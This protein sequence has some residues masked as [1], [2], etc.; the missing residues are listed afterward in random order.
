[1]RPAILFTTVLLMLMSQAVVINT[2]NNDEEVWWGGVISWYQYPNVDMIVGAKPLY[3]IV[4]PDYGP[5][6]EPWDPV[7]LER[8]HDAGIKVIAYLNIGFAEEW[9]DYWNTTWN[10]NNHPRWLYWV[11]YPDWPGEYFV[12]YWDPSAWGENGWV[13]ILK[14]ELK[15]IISMGFDGVRLD[16]IDSC[17][18]WE[19]PASY[20]L[21]D[22]LPQ[23]DNATQWMIY[24]VGNLSTY[25]KTLKEDF[26]I[27]ANMGGRLDLL[28]NTSFLEAIDIV[29]REDVWY[30]DN[31]PVDPDETSEALYWLRYARDH[32]KRVI[33]TDYAWK[34][35]YVWDALTKA[36]SEG[37]Y[38]Y[39]APSIDLD[40]LALYI[41]VYGWI[42]SVKTVNDEILVVWSYRGTYNN[43]W[44]ENSIYLGRITQNNTVEILKVLTGNDTVDFNPS[45][46]YDPDN[47]YVLCVWETYTDNGKVI[48]GVLID[49]NDMNIV[50]DIIIASGNN[51]GLPETIYYNGLFYIFYINNS[52][53]Y[54][55]VV[56]NSGEILYRKYIGE[57]DRKPWI[58][59]ARGEG[60]AVTWLCSNQSLITTK[61]IENSI[62][63]SR[64]IE[65][66]VTPLHYGSTYIPGKG[67]LVV[68]LKDNSSIAKVISEEGIV[69]MSKNNLPPIG[70]FPSVEYIEPDTIVYNGIDK[71]YYLSI[72]NLDYTGYEE[73]STS[74]ASKITIIEDNSTIYVIEPGVYTNNT[75]N[76][77]TIPVVPIPIPEPGLDILVAIITAIILIVLMNR[78][79]K[80]IDY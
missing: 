41:P 67:Y 29:E 31:T 49:L 56:D 43:S 38:I 33:V 51:V 14:K 63:W 3:V 26:I 27:I 35:E 42:D 36:R 22:V 58:T 17:D 37:F 2:V 80:S 71:I 74:I 8:F 52:D 40:R 39:V 50:S 44:L 12:A 61:I 23:V 77:E 16:N 70:W 10:E 54:Y 79:H 46:T 75:L 28:S 15:K 57:V 19:D 24:L 73:L 1:M 45:I 4:D 9:R 69:I 65:S 60:V 6:D 21:G 53:L 64:I 66:N 59:T 47:N 78:K 25:A 20:G 32:G 5:S 7:D 11:E 72:Q 62:S 18:I 34:Q 13:E 48:K 68:Y 30:T 76:V 55:V